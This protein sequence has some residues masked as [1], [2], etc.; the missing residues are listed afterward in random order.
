MMPTAQPMKK[1]SVIANSMQAHI[2]AAHRV[3]QSA[4]IFVAIVLQNIS[5]DQ[6]SEWR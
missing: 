5:L 4:D 2:S 3:H 1:T 6:E